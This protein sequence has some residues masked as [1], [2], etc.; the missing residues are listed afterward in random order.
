[1]RLHDGEYRCLFGINSLFFDRQAPTFRRNRVHQ[2]R[3][4][5]F[6][7]L[8]WR[9]RQQVG[10]CQTEL[11][12]ALSRSQHKH[13][14][15][16]ILNMFSQPYI[17]FIKR[18][19]DQVSFQV[20][21]SVATWRRGI[22]VVFVSNPP[23]GD[24]ASAN[25]SCFYTETTRLAALQVFCI[26]LCTYICMYVCVLHILSPPTTP[27]FP[28]CT[29]TAVLAPQYCPIYQ[30]HKHVALVPLLVRVIWNLLARKFKCLK[31]ETGVLFKRT[32]THRVAQ[33]SLDPR[34]NML[35]HEYEVTLVPLVIVW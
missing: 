10:I 34:G 6:A 30:L 18:S 1:L 21:L 25:W 19:C 8:P 29:Y 33:E 5:Q 11:L 22:A 7:S 4:Y 32:F 2:S 20:F 35:N 15:S 31:S 16:Q 28:R 12:Y 27:L 9:W 26:V 3:E 23:S 24:G 13:K 17:I 14:L